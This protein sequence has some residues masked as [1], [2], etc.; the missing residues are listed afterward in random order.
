M[1]FVIDS[2]Y[3]RLCS[4]FTV[5]CHPPKTNVTGPLNGCDVLRICPLEY[6]FRFPIKLLIKMSFG[7]FSMFLGYKVMVILQDFCISQNDLKQSQISGKVVALSKFTFAFKKHVK[8]FNRNVYSVIFV[9]FANIFEITFSFYG[10]SAP[11][12]HKKCHESLKYVLHPSTFSVT[13]FYLRNT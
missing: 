1:I 10:V 8:S 12:T 13:K 4:Y 5:L 6:I 3:L 2:K 9:I 7:N 11:K